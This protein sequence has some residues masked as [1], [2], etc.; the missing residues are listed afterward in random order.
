MKDINLAQGL[1]CLIMLGCALRPIFVSG[2]NKSEELR[3]DMEENWAFSRWHEGGILTRL[4]LTPFE[5]RFAA[6]FPGAIA[7]FSDGRTVWIVRHL[8]Q[9][10]RKLHPSFDCFRSLGYNVD[11]PKVIRQENGVHW[12]CFIAEKGRKLKVC[13]RIFDAAGG[14]WTDVSAWYW[15]TAFQTGSNEWWAVTEVTQA[16]TGTVIGNE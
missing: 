2:I 13:E 10:T 9:P 12:R 15:N 7:R 11:Q 6:D 14:E 1:F 4:P 8:N 16:E 3:A 5:N